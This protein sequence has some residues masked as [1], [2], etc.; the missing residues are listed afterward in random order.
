MGTCHSKETTLIGEI[1][2]KQKVGGKHKQTKA[3]EDAPGGGD[4]LF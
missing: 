2:G 3:A 4:G 1:T